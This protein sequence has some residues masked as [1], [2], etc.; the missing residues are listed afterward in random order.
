MKK[1]LLVVMMALCSLMGYCNVEYSDVL[2]NAMRNGYEKVSVNNDRWI[3]KSNRDSSIVVAKLILKTV[4]RYDKTYNINGQYVYVDPERRV[5]GMG[6]QPAET[7]SDYVIV[8][9]DFRN[10]IS[11]PENFDALIPW[12][13]LRIMK[14]G[15]C[16]FVSKQGKEAEEIIQEIFDNIEEYER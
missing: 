9:Y 11:I 13:G 2:I 12:H 14:D 7:K 5:A 10:A 16:V 6:V 15:I 8:I 4:Q 1:I 3:L